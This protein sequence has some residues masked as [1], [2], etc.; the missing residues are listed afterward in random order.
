MCNPHAKQFIKLMLRLEVKCSMI[1]HND[2]QTCSLS[3]MDKLFYVLLDFFHLTFVHYICF[4]QLWY[5]SEPSN[6]HEIGHFK[7]LW[8]LFFFR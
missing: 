1:L 2:R 4:S 5:L 3:E 8:P 7:E 6:S